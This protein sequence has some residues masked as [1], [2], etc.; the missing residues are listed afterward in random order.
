MRGSLAALLLAALLSAGCQ[1]LRYEAYPE[2]R[3]TPE[4]SFQTLRMAV[5]S[6]DPALLYRCFSDRLLE[7]LGIP[8][9]PVFNV[10][11]RTHSS[12]FAK[13]AWV[14]EDARTTDSEVRRGRDGRRYAFLTVE[15]MGGGAVFRLVAE[16]T[17]SLT[18]V[19]PDYPDEPQVAVSE[20]PW[21][22]WIEVTEEGAVVVRRPIDA[23]DT[24]V[25]SAEEIEQ[26]RMHFQ[27]SL[28]GLPAELAEALRGLA[29]GAAGSP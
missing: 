19:M 3:A 23:A 27:W 5:L 11:Y 17:V 24:G 6:E 1:A 2:S 18:V 8:S 20:R 9:Y 22:E 21:R 10:V 15:A 26:I 16:P 28:D 29:D 4:G 7:E 25:A 12:E 14:L 13:L